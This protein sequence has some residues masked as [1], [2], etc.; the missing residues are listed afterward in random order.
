MNNKTKRRIVC[1]LLLLV[2]SREL[3]PTAPCADAVANSHQQE[4]WAPGY[5]LAARVKR[6]L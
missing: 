5:D 3:D 6:F 2:A 4:P 1:L